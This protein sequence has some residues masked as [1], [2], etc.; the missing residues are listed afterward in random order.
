M[1]ASQPT[2]TRHSWNPEQDLLVLFTDGLSDAR[3]RG[4]Q[5]LGEEPLLEVIRKY[6]QETPAEILTRLIDVVEAHSGNTPRRDD[7][8]IVLLH[9]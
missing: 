7:Q 3:G 5:R 6:R 9:S 8:T 2:T 4:N 1:A